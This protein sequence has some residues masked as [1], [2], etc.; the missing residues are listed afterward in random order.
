MMG[1][2]GHNILEPAAHGK[3]VFFGPDISNF[4]DSR[5]LLLKNDAGIQVNSWQ[6]LKEQLL[7]Y[8]IFG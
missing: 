1:K 5:D 2:G 6:S 8:K 3:L 7:Y 4:K